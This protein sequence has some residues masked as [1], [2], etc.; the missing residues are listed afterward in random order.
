MCECM[1]MTQTH[2]VSSCV[3]YSNST[4]PR[5]AMTDRSAIIS[6]LQFHVPQPPN[7]LCILADAAQ[8]RKGSSVCVRTTW[9]MSAPTNPQPRCVARVRLEL[10][11][12]VCTDRDHASPR[13]TTCI[14]VYNLRGFP[15]VCTASLALQ[16]A[17]GL[18]LIVTHTLGGYP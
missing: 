9:A 8:R 17:I 11:F 5:H 6:G 7:H 10:S 3:I 1:H 16:N 14:C 18:R 12:H 2:M 4:L 13:R 15:L